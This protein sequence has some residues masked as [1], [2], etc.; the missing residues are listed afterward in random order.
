[1]KV[2]TKIAIISLVFLGSVA[3]GLFA[4][5]AGKNY[6]TKVNI[7]YEEPGRI[8]TTNYHRGTI[9]PM[10]TKVQLVSINKKEIK[11]TFDGVTY[12]IVY[13]PKHASQPLEKMFENYFSEKDVWKVNIIWKSRKISRMVL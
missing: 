11:F 1:M 9:I 8:Y 7:W 13:M 5:E 2:F 3:P 12:A 10:G 6:F 4:Q